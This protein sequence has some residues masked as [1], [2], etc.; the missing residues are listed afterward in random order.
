MRLYRALVIPTM[1]YGAAAF[2]TAT[3][4]AQREF[5]QVQRSA[6][7]KATGCLSNTSFDTLELLTNCIPTYLHLK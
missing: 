3:D 1:D 4:L 7:L 5:N 2:V 6:L